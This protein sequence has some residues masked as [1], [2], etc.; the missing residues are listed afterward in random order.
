MFFW[1]VGN[2]PKDN[3]GYHMVVNPRMELCGAFI[4]YTVKGKAKGKKK[5]G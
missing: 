4:N 1:K 5:G 2:V 3:L